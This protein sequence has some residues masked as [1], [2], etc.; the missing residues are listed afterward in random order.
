M[1]SLLPHQTTYERLAL[2]TP[3]KDGTCNVHMTYRTRHRD[4]QAGRRQ[5]AMNRMLMRKLKVE[6]NGG[7]ST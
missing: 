3:T 6:A 7:R 4:R 1:P 2:T 5:V